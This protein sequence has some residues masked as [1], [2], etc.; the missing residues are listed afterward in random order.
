MA[1]R[2]QNWSYTCLGESW[3]LQAV[4]DPLHASKSIATQ[5]IFSN[6][7]WRFCKLQNVQV[8]Q[9]LAVGLQVELCVGVTQ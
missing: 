2:R 1:Q 7:I 3:V 4:W 9:S 5:V 8:K 6:G